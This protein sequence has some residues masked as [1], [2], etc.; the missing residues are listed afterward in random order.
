MDDEIEGSLQMFLATRHGRPL[1]FN[2]IAIFVEACILKVKSSFLATNDCKFTKVVTRPIVNQLFTSVVRDIIEVT[3]VPKIVLAEKIVEAPR[4][5]TRATAST[6]DIV[7]AVPFIC[8]VR[9]LQVW[10]QRAILPT[11][12]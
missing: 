11:R 4:T 6:G 1:L 10:L 7:M 12:M 3:A 5:R 9:E 8:C 2:D